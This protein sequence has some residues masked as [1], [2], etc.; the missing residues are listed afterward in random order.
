[1][2]RNFLISYNGRVGSTA[3]IDTLKLIPGFLIPVFEELDYYAMEAE[4][5]LDTVNAENIHETIDF[6]YKN[7]RQ[8][9]GDEPTS[10]G[11]K[12]RIWGNT[13]KV[14]QSLL[15]ND[16][17]VFNIIRCDVFEF[18]SS[19]YLSNV[20]HKDFNAPQF[21]LRD[22]T[23]EA[24]RMSVLAKYRIDTTDVD[25]NEY[26][27]VYD[28][29]YSQEKERITL[30]QKMHKDGVQVF[31]IVYEDFAYK[32]FRF[33]QKLM[34]VLCHD[35]LKTFPLPSL[36]KVSGSYPSEL[37]TNRADLLGSDRLIQALYDWDHLIYSSNFD[38]M[39]V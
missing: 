7:N 32:R 27:R 8:K 4:G 39:P 5:R 31:T 34:E 22:A 25:V 26:F 33:L 11:F 24:E 19:L 23:S 2:S 12:W 20:T 36:R 21:M 13:E 3:L 10:I 30:L 9:V 38:S 37:F 35:S 6:V 1:M 18:V 14:S 28:D 16:V 17:V 15:Q 29:L